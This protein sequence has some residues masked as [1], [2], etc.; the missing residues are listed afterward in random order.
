[1]S[2]NNESNIN[3]NKAFSKKPLRSL[4]DL[5]IEKVTGVT[6]RIKTS[7]PERDTN[8]T[9]SIADRE[10]SYTFTD[11]KNST[12]EKEKA[13]TS[14]QIPHEEL[15]KLKAN[16]AASESSNNALKKKTETLS[17]QLDDVAKKTQSEAST[18]SSAKNTE[19]EL[20]SIPKAHDTTLVRRSVSE[21]FNRSGS[22]IDTAH[23]SENSAQ[24]QETADNYVVD[25]VSSIKEHTANVRI[26][27]SERKES[28]TL[29]DIPLSMEYNHESAQNSV[30]QDIADH[31]NESTVD[32]T[33]PLVQ[34]NATPRMASLDELYT[35]KMGN[36]IEKTVVH[37][38]SSKVIPTSQSEVR[39]TH[40]QENVDTS[41]KNR[42]QE[43]ET[44]A[45]DKKNNYLEHVENGT[46]RRESE[47]ASQTKVLTKSS[48]IGDITIH[49][50]TGI[51]ATP[52]VTSTDPV[53]SAVDSTVNMIHAQDTNS[54]TIAERVKQ[55]EESGII[56]IKN[57]SETNRFVDRIGKKA[58]TNGTDILLGSMH[59][60]IGSIE[61]QAVLAHELTHVSQ[62][63]KAQKSGEQITQQKIAEF[64][65]EAGVI[66]QRIFAKPS[67][68]T[69]AYKSPMPVLNRSNPRSLSTRIA[70]THVHGERTVVSPKMA[71]PATV[72]RVISSAPAQNSSPVLAATKEKELLSPSDLMNEGNEKFST[73]QEVAASTTQN[74]NGINIDDLSDQVFDK[75]K[76]RLTVERE[77]FH[78]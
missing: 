10:L 7:L 11:S 65:R 60:N 18:F 76:D 48:E 46:V 35:Q 53:I 40:S 75:I 66:E 24:N 23:L 20:V 47:L 77:R 31:S 2:L 52:K 42:I 45:L 78:K 61:S 32:R 54:Q 64:E 70:N 57:D 22:G 13:S 72:Q 27:S 68:E 12:S 16:L 43:L 5:Y 1:M 36:S 59:N 29:A 50:K 34:S 14:E 69:P 33:T 74:S 3:Q 39:M 30:S 17:K 63:R 51:P 55:L 58:L 62:I 6:S 15:G 49:S 71:H 67:V 37:S 73:L 9:I 41:I 38:T 26:L 25:K 8:S 44:A 19:E 4:N 56:S 28:A 21:L